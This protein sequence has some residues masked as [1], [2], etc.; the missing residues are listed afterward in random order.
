MGGLTFASY[1]LITR[2]IVQ[3]V[4]VVGVSMYP[5]LRNSQ[6]YLLNRWI[7]YLRGPR[8]GDI[9]VLRDPVD[10]SLAV[11][12]IVAGEGDNVLVKTGRVYVNGQPLAEPYLTP[13]MP[14]F[15]YLSAH[16]QSFHCGQDQYFVLGDNRLN[17]ADS[18]TYGAVTRRNILGLIIR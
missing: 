18:R 17:S 5:T 3:S 8:R 14:T 2:L 16:E 4:E 11:K 10:H 9:V 13:G 1:F 6:H 12:R 15:P 7:L